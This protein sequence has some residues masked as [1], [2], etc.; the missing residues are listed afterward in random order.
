VWAVQSGRV[1]WFSKDKG[2]GFVVV[3][4]MAGD[5]FVH[6]NT[7]K[8]SNLKP[9]QLQDDTLVNVEVVEHKGRQRASAI[10]LR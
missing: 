4:G 7:V 10:E 6:S 5:V 1:K 8:A 3:D 2:F 9:E